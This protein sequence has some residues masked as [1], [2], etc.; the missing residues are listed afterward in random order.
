MML[1]SSTVA[2]PVAARKSVRAARRAPVKAMAGRT[3]SWCPGAEL[4]KHL[5]G[6]L[7]GD[8]GYDPLGL[9]KDPDALKWYAVA[10]I[11]HGR[12]AMMGAA[13]ILIPDAMTKLGVWDV[14]VWYEAG[15]VAA[16][17]GVYAPGNPW[18]D[19]T[20]HI[21]VGGGTLLLAQL[22]L[23]AF[24]E[25]KRGWDIRNAGSQAAAGSFLG[26]EKSLAGTGNPSYPGGLFDPFQFSKRPDFEMMKVKEIKNGRL[27]MLGMLGFYLQAATRGGSPLDNLST[28]LADP[29]HTTVIANEVAAHF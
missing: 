9:A 3:Q 8:F 4:P 10:E 24:V 22:T 21:T 14:P 6:T 1:T 15:Q 5:D 2:A 29:Y 17:S 12:M 18:A 27:A 26:F 23:S 25:I 11:F 28:H 13:G 7:P 19:A 16:E 20:G